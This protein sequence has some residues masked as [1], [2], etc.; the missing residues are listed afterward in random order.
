MRPVIILLALVAMALGHAP[1]GREDYELADSDSSFPC[2]RKLEL[3]ESQS[4][5]GGVAGKRRTV[6]KHLAPLF[7]AADQGRPLLGPLWPPA[8][9]GVSARDASLNCALAENCLRLQI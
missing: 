3:N 7:L 6:V 4:S 9:R 5:S 2:V 8:S 1:R